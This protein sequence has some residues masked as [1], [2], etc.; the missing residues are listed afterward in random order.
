[1]SA[2]RVHDLGN[3]RGIEETTPNPRPCGCFLGMDAEQQGRVLEAP[4]S[5]QTVK[6]RPLSSGAE[7]RRLVQAA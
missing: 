4:S 6:I 7:F 5:G 1:M 3:P 2:Q